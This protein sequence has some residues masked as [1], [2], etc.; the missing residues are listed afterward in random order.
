[1]SNQEIKEILDHIEKCKARHS[2]ELALVTKPYSDLINK[3]NQDIEDAIKADDGPAFLRAWLPRSLTIKGLIF[4]EAFVYELIIRS[5]IDYRARKVFDF[6]V[7]NNDKFVQFVRPNNQDFAGEIGENIHE[8]V[9]EG[10]EGWG[11]ITNKNVSNFKK[12]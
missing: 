11:I 1:M 12:L 3:N 7:K 4:D 9:Q 5:I 2:K 10:L 6:I 8:E